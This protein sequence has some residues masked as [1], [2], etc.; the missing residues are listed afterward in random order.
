MSALGFLV[1]R[2]RRPLLIAVAAGAISGLAGAGVISLVQE[3][4]SGDGRPAAQLA[5]GFA[6]LAAVGV[7]S[8][9]VS[10]VLLTRLGQAMI[11][12]LRMQ[13]SRRI[14]DAPLRH[15]EQLGAHRLLAALNDDPAV[16]TQAYVVLPLLCVNVATVLGCLAYI[17][18]ISWSALAIVLGAMGV[19]AALFRW[20]A[21]RAIGAFTRARETS[22][23]LFQH[24]RGLT[25]GIK[26]LKMHGRRGRSFLSDV[27]GGSVATYQREFVAG[28]TEYAV[29]MGWGALLFYAVLG[30]ALFA[31][32]AWAGLAPPAVSGVVLAMLF[33]MTPFAQTVEFLPAVGRASVA[34]SKAS[35]LGL[36]LTPEQGPTPALDAPTSEGRAEGPRAF[37]RIELSGVTHR[38]HREKED[39]SFQLGPIDLAFRP[40]ELVF[41][42]GGN[43][44]GKTTL[45]LL[46]LGLYAPESGE[47]R[48][49][50]APVDDANR[51]R[52]RQLFSVVFADY[53]LFE[54]LLGLDDPGL[55]E[56]ARRYLER[57]Q[58]DHR[59]RVEE[60]ALRVSGLSQGQRKRLALLTAY[61][62]DRP[63][64]VFDEWASDQDP[65]FRRVFYTEL[66]PELRARGKTALVITHDDQ[67]F[68]LADRCLRLDFGRLTE[69][70]A[71]PAA[72]GAA[73]R[74]TREERAVSARVDE[75][76]R[77]RSAEALRLHVDPQ[78]AALE[79]GARG[80]EALT[81]AKQEL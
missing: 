21:R 4:L 42:V 11:A 17:G 12:E 7:L 22:D 1:R 25:G 16:I 19:G 14:L 74:A 39:G 13:L 53:H 8:R 44:S 72:P 68:A 50:D 35:A 28:T 64:Y 2:A 63:F 52:Y 26:E 49:D 67:Y 51:E 76:G 66:L 9:T 6:G 61:L 80:H 24:F 18:Q 36:A 81:A 34:L 31:L 43:G 47:I 23:A 75:P 69:L 37:E 33:L 79:P 65:Q 48:L 56:R 55:D 78:Q 77:V 15:V 73:P 5:W 10:Q 59:V 30:L 40:G 46:L 29:A 57:L 70:P 41:L 32:P 54:H 60:G 45:S 58:L 38:Y 27:L 71:A 20:H 3:A 62:E